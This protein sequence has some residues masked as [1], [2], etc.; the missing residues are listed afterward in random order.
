MI[1]VGCATTRVVAGS[2][3]TTSGVA[4]GS[5][6]GVAAGVVVGSTEVVSA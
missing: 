1:V 5:A 6:D 2:T 4:T 3:G